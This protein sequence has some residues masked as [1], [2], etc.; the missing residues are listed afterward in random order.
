MKQPFTHRGLHGQRRD[1][2][3]GRKQYYTAWATII[4]L[5]KTKKLSYGR[6]SAMCFVFILTEN[7]WYI[8]FKKEAKR[9]TETVCREAKGAKVQAKK[10]KNTLKRA[11][12]EN[13]TSERELWFVK[14]PSLPQPPNLRSDRAN[15]KEVHIQP[16]RSTLD[17]PERNAV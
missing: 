2:D 12:W 8:F 11:D 13:H 4:L 15:A 17:D 5:K 14:F 7:K 3:H 9:Y 16:N 1:E 6:L 10:K